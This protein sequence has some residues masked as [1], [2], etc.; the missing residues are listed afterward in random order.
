VRRYLAINWRWDHD[1]DEIADRRS[2]SPLTCVR[3]RNLALHTA[4]QGEMSVGVD[5]LPAMATFITG[6]HRCPDCGKTQ[7][8]S[9]AFQERRSAGPR[10]DWCAFQFPSGHVWARPGMQAVK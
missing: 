5:T 9:R 8:G 4:G 6:T 2:K 1:T 7:T 10:V 3:A